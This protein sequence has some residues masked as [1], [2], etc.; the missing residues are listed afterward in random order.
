MRDVL[1]KGCR[2]DEYLWQN[3]RLEDVTMVDTNFSGTVM[4]DEIPKELSNPD[5]LKNELDR[6]NEAMR[7]IEAGDIKDVRPISIN[8]SNTAA[9]DDLDYCQ[10]Y[11]TRKLREW[12][13]LANGNKPWWQ[14]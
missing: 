2:F 14:W 7:M 10:D 6:T 4:G 1:F 5:W 13:E 9:S 8:T 11:K 3:D 12:E